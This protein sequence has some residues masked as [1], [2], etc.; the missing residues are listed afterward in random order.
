MNIN[1]IRPATNA[2][3]STAT[4]PLRIVVQPGDVLC[5]YL[6]NHALHIVEGAAL[7]TWAGEEIALDTGTTAPFTS[8]KAPAVI[9]AR[10]GEP[11]TLEVVS[12]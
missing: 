9:S 11:L 6:N 8:G 10:N 5:L 4:N 2:D 12:V 1:F 7:V 3:E